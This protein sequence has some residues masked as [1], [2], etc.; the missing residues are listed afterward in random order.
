MQ[1]IKFVVYGEPVPKLR[2]RV[3]YRANIGRPI[4]ISNPKTV[5]YE[6]AIRHA[7]SLNRPPI[8][9]TEMVILTISVFRSIPKSMPKKKRELAIREK[10]RPTSKPDLDNY[11]KVKDALNG[12]IWRDDSQVVRIIADKYYSETPR[13]EFEVS[14]ISGEEAAPL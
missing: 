12:I 9:L 8:P 3:V 2:P 10:L 4:A 6:D 14:T 1:P 7:A 5:S 11:V 13:I